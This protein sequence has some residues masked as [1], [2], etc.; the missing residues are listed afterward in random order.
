M[1]L[2]VIGAKGIVGQKMLQII[3]ERGIQYDHLLVAASDSSIGDKIFVKGKKY[4]L[5]SVQDVLNQKPDIAL[6]SAGGAASKDWAVKFA[7]SGCYVIDNSSCWRMHEN[8]PLVV[9][10]INGYTITSSHKII[11]NPNCSTIQLVAVLNPL[12]IAFQLKRVVV[13]TYQSVSGSGINGI[14]QLMR[15][16]EG[17]FEFK[18]YPHQIDLNVLPHGGDFLENGYTSEEMK[19]LDESRKILGIP[20]L[21]LTSTVVRVPVIGGHSESVTIEFEK[22]FKLEDVSR[23]LSSTDGIVVEDDVQHN[24]YP[25]P[26]NAYEKDDIFVG[27][28]RLDLCQPKT[29]NLWI[30][31]DNVRKGAATNAVQILEYLLNNKIVS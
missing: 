7:D 1:R 12:H 30:V 5:I 10:E 22:E 13:S 29:L 24:I 23:L 17:D 25:M 21:N 11:A 31:S 4:E 20:E 28:I 18:I 3:H 14:N 16:R 15:E 19:L 26:V 8:I 2:A 27:R 6:F 9:P